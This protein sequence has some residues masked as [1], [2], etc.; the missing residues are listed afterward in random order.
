MN[1]PKRTT[2]STG[3]NSRGF[4]F[5]EVMVTLV[6]LSAG[7]VF[8]YKTFF[9]C[10]DYLSRLTIRLYAGQLVE[11]RIADLQRKAQASGGLGFERGPMSV[12]QEFNHKPVEFAFQI[13]LNPVH[14]FE[15]LYQMQVGVSWVDGGRGNNFKRLAM[16]DL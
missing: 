8:I 16:V 7:I 15:D 11:A 14:G 5:V 4:T 12:R 10:V 3:N 1:P 6:I 13:D 9:L 2:S